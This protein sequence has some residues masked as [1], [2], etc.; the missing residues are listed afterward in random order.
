MG[1]SF[2][3]HP[4]RMKRRTQQEMEIPNDVV[5]EEILARL[6][7]KSL[8]RFKCVSKLWSSLI[9][10]R[11]F[12]NRFLTVPTRPRPRIYMCLQDNNDYSNSVTLSLAPD[13]TNPNCFVVDHNLTSP[14]VGGYVLQNLC[15]FMCYSF[16]RKPKIYNPATRQ[17]VTIPAAIKSP[18]ITPVPPE[19]EAITEFSYYFGYDPVIDQYNVLWSTGVYLKH[20]GE[21]RSQHLVFVLKAGGKGSWKKASPTPPDYLPHTPAK[22]GMCIDGVIYYMG[23]TGRYSLWLVSFHI[24]SGDFKM[25]QVP[26]R[27]GDEV[28]LRTMENVSLIEYGGKVTIIDLTNLREKGMLDLWA[29][30]NAGNKKSWSRKTMVLQSSQLHLVISNKTIYNMKG[31]TDNN[32]VFFIP[33]DMFS[34]FYILCYDLRSNDMT[35]IEIKGIPDHWFNIDRSTVMLMDQSETLVCLET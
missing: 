8:M 34:P 3:H 23:W 27:D 20:L 9:R 6:P 4:K 22:R 5:I 16:M 28:F 25:I 35:K 18:N 13:T 2:I 1:L 29:V 12:S 21:T 14:R 7:A 24:R 32:K 11:Y 17:L 26:G 33:V 19:E 10:S 31:T 15:G 30:E